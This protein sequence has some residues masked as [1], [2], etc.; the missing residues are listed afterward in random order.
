MG[1]RLDA[2]SVQWPG[3]VQRPSMAPECG[4]ER[5]GT[6]RHTGGVECAAA[7]PVAPVVG[8]AGVGVLAH[9]TACGHGRATGGGGTNLLPTTHRATRLKP[10]P[11]AP[12]DGSKRLKPQWHQAQHQGGKFQQRRISRNERGRPR[13]V[14]Q[15]GAAGLMSQAPSLI[16]AGPGP[17]SL[18][19][20]HMGGGGRKSPDC[21]K[22]TLPS[23]A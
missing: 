7:I 20:P 1:W 14:A 22:T 8:V 21:G 23:H 16:R 15:K 3:G 5:G 18:L 6:S 12:C 17:N 19:N 9:G 2:G 4:G 10:P 13:W 11:H